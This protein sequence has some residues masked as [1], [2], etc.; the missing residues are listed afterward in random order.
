MR[1][2]GLLVDVKQAPRL[3]INDLDSVVGLIYQGP[4]QYQ[5][6]LCPL[7]RLF[8]PLA[9]CDLLGFPQRASNRPAQATQV[10]FMDVVLGARFEGFHGALFPNRAGNKKEGNLRLRRFGQGQRCGPTKGR[11][12]KIGKDQIEFRMIQSLSE[13]SRS[14]RIYKL[15]IQLVSEQCLGY[16]FSIKAVVFEVKD[17]DNLPVFRFTHERCNTSR[18]ASPSGNLPSKHSLE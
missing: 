4:E 9:F 12:R 5:R 18:S 17:A 3:R 16:Q 6:L 10:V 7:Q 13:L 14:S 2:T 1:R 11:Q 8:R 15:A